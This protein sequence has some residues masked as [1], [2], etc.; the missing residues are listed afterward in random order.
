MERAHGLPR[1]DRQRRPQGSTYLT[2]VDYDPYPLLVELDGKLG[3]AGKGR[4]RD[5][6]RDNTHVLLGRMTLRYGHAD[7]LAHPCAMAWEVADLLMRY[8]W[9]GLPMRCRRCARSRRQ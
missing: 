2:D 3:H 4:F 7:V 1:G 5:M 9:A 8:G 6:R